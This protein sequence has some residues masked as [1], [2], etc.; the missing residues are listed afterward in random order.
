MTP[1]ELEKNRRNL[2]AALRADIEP[3]RA[4]AERRKHWLHERLNNLLPELMRRE[5]L[6]C[7]IVVAREYNE[8]PVIMTLLPAPAMSARRRTILLFLRK[9]DGQVW[10]LALD[11][12]GYR[13]FYEP[14]WDPEQEEQFACLGR[15]LREHDPQRI[16][17]NIAADFAFGDGLSH[18]EYEQ[19]ASA[20]GPE[21]MER[22]CSAE[23][24]AVGW[25][26]RRLPAEIEFYPCL[27]EFGHR[28]IAAAFS[29]DAVIPGQTSAD[30]LVWWMRQTM[31]DAGLQAWFQ[32][33]I[34]IQAPGHPF[35]LEGEKRRLIQPGDLLHCD[36]GFLYLGLA[37]DQQQNAYVL[38]PGEQ[39]APPGLR[40]A[41]AAGNRLQD[42]LL[43]EMHV[44]RNGNQ[45]LLA[46]LE[47]ARTEGITPSI[48]SHPLGY[49]G[50]AAGP[51]IGLWDYQDGVPG[52]GDYPLFDDTCY[53]IELNIRAP[54]AEWDGQEVRIA[55]EEDATLTQGRMHWMHSRQTEFY[56]IH[57]AAV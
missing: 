20:L 18:N 9:P 57:P 2:V 22:T 21:L 54:V 49:H 51:P 47:R 53:S 26:E 28:I 42:I 43:E 14:A 8:D 7:W 4:Q 33:T 56:L 37:S 45:V 32:P 50:H 17:L 24:L 48:Y 15:L 44:G 5:N 23:R 6:D 19:L 12:Y 38:R 13:D 40:A 3:L 16:G 41:L 29:N 35:N 11:R 27:A 1:D 34:D 25:L 10:C 55:L 36:M 31:H 30:D 46:A 39:V 52:R